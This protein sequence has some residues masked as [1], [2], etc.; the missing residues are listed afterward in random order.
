MDQTRTGHL[1]FHP[2]VMDESECKKKVSN[3]D[4]SI[5]AKSFSQLFPEG[6][7]GRFPIKAQSPSPLSDDCWFWSLNAQIS[8]SS[9][10]KFLLPGVSLAFNAEVCWWP[11]RFVENKKQ[12]LCF[13]VGFWRQQE[14][15]ISVVREERGR[16]RLDWD[17]EWLKLFLKFHRSWVPEIRL[18]SINNDFFWWQME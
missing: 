5:T 4:Q 14:T 13:S 7:Q 1:T 9:R 16:H 6:R 15:S 17:I 10:N 11:L 8:E 2:Q 3:I 18:S 12:Y